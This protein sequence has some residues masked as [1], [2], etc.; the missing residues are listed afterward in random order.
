MG[1]KKDDT[2][3]KSGRGVSFHFPCHYG[4]PAAELCLSPV[5]GDPSAFLPRPAVFQHVFGPV[6]NRHHFRQG[7]APDPDGAVVRHRIPVQ[8]VQHRRAGTV[9]HRGDL[10][11]FRHAWPAEPHSR[12]SRDPSGGPGRFAGRRR[13]RGT[14][15]P[16][17]GEI[18]CQRISRQHDVHLRYR[19]TDGLPA[20]H[21]SA[22][23]GEGLSADGFHRPFRLAAGHRRQNERPPGRGPRRCGGA[24]RLGAAVQNAG[25]V[26]HPRGRPERGSRED[27][28]HPAGNAV[29]PDAV[30]QRAFGGVRRVHRGKR[31]AAY[32][33][34]RT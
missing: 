16:A 17:E 20:P 8:P 2:K 12:L 5:Y 29:Y 33:D 4:G 23:K 1:R 10:R 25:R 28:R 31:N 24:P 13:G 30:H 26:P 9:L 18:P 22:G 6:H 7:R 19:G 27:V 15:R 3:N 34:H 32:A 14:D 21:F 11:G